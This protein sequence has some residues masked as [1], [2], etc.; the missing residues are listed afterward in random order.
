MSFNLLFDEN[1]KKLDK[2]YEIIDMIEDYLL[3]D[4]REYRD[5]YRNIEFENH[6]LSDKEMEALNNLRSTMDS[7]IG[8]WTLRLKFMNDF[9]QFMHGRKDAKKMLLKEKSEWKD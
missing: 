7:K 3:L 8:F 5:K 4:H 2:K 6:E 9:N 1:V